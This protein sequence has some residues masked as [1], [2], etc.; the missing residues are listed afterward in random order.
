MRTPCL[1]DRVTCVL[2]EFAIQI[3]LDTNKLICFIFNIISL[4]RNMK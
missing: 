3:V 2:R 1:F 4:Q